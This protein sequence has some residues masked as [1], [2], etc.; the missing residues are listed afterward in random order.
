MIQYEDCFLLCND[1]VCLEVD[2]EVVEVS[3][4]VA[5]WVEILWVPVSQKDGQ[6]TVKVYVVCSPVP[7]PLPSFS[8]V[9]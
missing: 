8:K 2:R 7:L 5:R 1:K 3:V 6:V 9:E 4:L